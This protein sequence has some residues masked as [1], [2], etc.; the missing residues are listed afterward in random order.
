SRTRRH[1][2]P[3]PGTDRPRPSTRRPS[4]RVQGTSPDEPDAVRIRSPPGTTTREDPMRRPLLALALSAVLIGAVAA[5]PA[6]AAVVI[7]GVHTTS[8]Y[9]WKP[10]AVS[11]ATGTKVV[12]KAV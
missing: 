7:Q 10:H 11:V 1:R 3:P 8:G 12:W 9:R 4:S 2:E 6:Q 5:Q